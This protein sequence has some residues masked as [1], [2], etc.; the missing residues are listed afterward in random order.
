MRAIDQRGQNLSAQP[1]SN[2]PVVLADR[3]K[4]IESLTADFKHLAAIVLPLAKVD[5]LLD[6]TSNNLA[7]WRSETQRTFTIQERGLL[8]RI[9][10]LVLA[11]ILI[12]RR[13]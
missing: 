9:G 12:V 13:R 2:D 1:Q 5:V 7:E 3:R 11:I 6:A 4:Q 10:A 8:L